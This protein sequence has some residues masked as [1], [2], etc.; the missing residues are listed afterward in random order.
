VKGL[1]I[2][3]VLERAPTITFGYLEVVGMYIF[4]FPLVL[5]NEAIRFLTDKTER[6][7]NVVR[8][9]VNILPVLSTCI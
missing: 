2:R 7:L 5:R 9:E 4:G 3:T 6:F 8:A 1:A